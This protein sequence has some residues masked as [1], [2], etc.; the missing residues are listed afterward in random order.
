MSMI[1]DDR[2]LLRRFGKT[3]S[4]IV[5]IHFVIL[6]GYVGVTLVPGNA[7]AVTVI[8]PGASLR[9]ALPPDIRVI[10]WNKWT[11]QLASNNPRFVRGLY[12]A[13]AVLVLP[14]LDA[15]CISLG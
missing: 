8:M 3:L 1:T 4:V 10:S 7:Q 9:S 11:A 13:G 15:F 5:G 6:A 14:T 12:R 2:P